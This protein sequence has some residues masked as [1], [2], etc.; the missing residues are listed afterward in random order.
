MA[1]FLV[2]GGA[3]FIGSHTTRMLLDMGH[4]VTVFDVPPDDAT[5]RPPSYLDNVEYRIEHLLKGARIVQGST[6][7]KNSLRR[8]LGRRYDFVL[9][10]AA[11]PQSGG[12]LQRPE[13]AF[14][15]ILRGTLNLVTLLP[16]MLS[17]TKFVYVSSSMIYG[18][19]KH[20][21]TPEHADKDP[22]EIY[23]G[24][25]LA[26]E[27]LVK[28]F[29]KQFGVRY[30]IVRPS[31]VYGPTNN[32]RS[33]LQ[34][35]VENALRQLPIRVVN[36]ATTYLD[37]TYV[38]DVARGLTQVALSHDAVNEDFNLTRGEGRSLAEVVR[39]LGYF[40]PTLE[41]DVEER[42]ADFR[43]NRGTLDVG[44][45]RRQVGYDPQYSLEAGLEEYIAFV[46]IH[47]PS[48][49]RDRATTAV[50]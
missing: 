42:A 39:L 18:D 14:D 20:T 44:K 30:A 33:V 49:M 11:S 10:L 2:T 28:V 3:G 50:V 26:A 9:H 16:E 8:L 21:P 23:G 24:M 38:K 19:F 34:I 12:A 36:P 37:F 45:A 47:N 29:S 48:L 40:F 35:F 31:A 13:E 22:K 32:N 27:V 41:V 25:K 7:D 43:P 6:L 15:G 5:D 1:T 17:V 4:E 46:R